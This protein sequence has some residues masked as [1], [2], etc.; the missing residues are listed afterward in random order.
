MSSESPDGK[1]LQKGQ[2]ES[3]RLNT[4]PEQHAAWLGSFRAPQWLALWFPWL[5]EAHL[6]CVH[7]Q[8]WL[9]LGI[10]YSEEGWRPEPGEPQWLKT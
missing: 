2:L 1:L 5:G 3:L 8:A 10:A 6:P 9:S 4:E 7:P